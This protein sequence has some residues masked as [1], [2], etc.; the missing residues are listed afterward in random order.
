[1]NGGGGTK[2]FHLVGVMLYFVIQSNHY[3]YFCYVCIESDKK[4]VRIPF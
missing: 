2:T 1:M 4:H 3:T